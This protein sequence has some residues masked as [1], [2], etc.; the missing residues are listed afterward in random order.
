MINIENSEFSGS[1]SKII[2]KVA[3][4][5]AGQNG[6]RWLS[7]FYRTV[8]RY[9]SNSAKAAF[10]NL[11]SNLDSGLLASTEPQPKVERVKKK[12]K[13]RAVEICSSSRWP[14][15]KK[16]PRRF[17]QISHY[18]NSQ[19]LSIWCLFK[20][21]SALSQASSASAWYGG[22]RGRKGFSKIHLFDYS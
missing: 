7:C 22:G 3:L 10:K 18:I 4:G 13:K 1:N 9:R 6:R 16:W 19:F 15:F 11:F 5:R 8:A 20:P 2:L 14:S 17:F 21:D 12:R